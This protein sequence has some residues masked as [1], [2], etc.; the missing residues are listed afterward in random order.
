V[1][2]G[3][4]RDRSLSRILLSRRCCEFLADRV[5]TRGRNNLVEY[6]SAAARISVLNSVNVCCL[7]EFPLDIP[8][9]GEIYAPETFSNRVST[10]S[11]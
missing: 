9:A 2:Q 6:F 8:N 7:L 10:Q 3:S 11:A 4:L 5:K 1:R